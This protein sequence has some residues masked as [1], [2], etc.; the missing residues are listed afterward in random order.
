MK[1][2]KEAI[3]SIDARIEWCWASTRMFLENKDA[4]GVMDSGAELQSLQRAKA[5][6]E[7]LYEA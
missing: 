4:R 6:L 5:E 7:K 2:I 3:K 1:V